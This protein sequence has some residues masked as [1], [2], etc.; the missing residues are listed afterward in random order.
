MPLFFDLFSHRRFFSFSFFW[1]P[2]PIF[3]SVVVDSSQALSGRERMYFFSIAHTHLLFIRGYYVLLRFLLEGD[4][5]NNPR[6]LHL[7]RKENKKQANKK[8]EKQKQNRKK[9]PPKNQ[10]KPNHSIRIWADS[11]L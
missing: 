2:T 11:D 7:R 1:I 8:Q 5:K 10:N 6:G 9:K 3:S 4:D